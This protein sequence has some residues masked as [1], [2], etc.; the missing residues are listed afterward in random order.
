MTAIEP[1]RHAGLE[2]GPIALRIE[3]QAQRI[4]IV[5]ADRALSLPGRERPD[6]LKFGD[7]GWHGFAHALP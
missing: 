3:A 2:P 4:A 1:D 6:R 7:D 5:I